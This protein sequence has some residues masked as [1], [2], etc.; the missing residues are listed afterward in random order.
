MLNQGD[1]S[2]MSLRVSSS[3]YGCFY[4]DKVRTSSQIQAPYCITYLF[5]SLMYGLS[6]PASAPFGAFPAAFISSIGPVSDNE[7]LVF[8]ALDFFLFALLPSL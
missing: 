8:S 5:N 4:Q 7:A 3:S 2:A 1:R 6:A